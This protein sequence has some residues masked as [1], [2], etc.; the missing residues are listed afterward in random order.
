MDG[1]P[2]LCGHAF[3]PKKPSMGACDGTG[4][5]VKRKGITRKDV[6]VGAEVFWTD[7]DRGL[8]SGV[9]KITECPDSKFVAP[10]S[11]IHISNGSSEA[12]VFMSELSL[13]SN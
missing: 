12:E 10:D 9:Y 3:N 11:I 7:P 13:N 5:V 8:S 2:R 1:I 6:F 4:M